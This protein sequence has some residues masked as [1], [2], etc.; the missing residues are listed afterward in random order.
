MKLKQMKNKNQGPSSV[1][2]IMKFNESLGGY[3]LSPE[4]IIGA[5][6]GFVV[7]ILILKM[8]I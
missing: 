4:F 1:I 2:G 5:S 7:L 8:F 3:K 6:I